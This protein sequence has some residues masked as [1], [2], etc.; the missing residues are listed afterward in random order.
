MTRTHKKQIVT[1]WMNELSSPGVN[2]QE[3]AE[4]IYSVGELDLWPDRVAYMSAAQCVACWGII[5]KIMKSG[6]PE[7]L[8]M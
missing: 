7:E 2:K 6:F 4:A 5:E 3:L 8:R 1:E